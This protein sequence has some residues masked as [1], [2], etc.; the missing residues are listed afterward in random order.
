MKI[1]TMLNAENFRS[2]VSLYLGLFWG[3]AGFGALRMNV[4]SFTELKTLYYRGMLVKN[5]VKN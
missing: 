4:P 5:L 1:K 3:A 2:V